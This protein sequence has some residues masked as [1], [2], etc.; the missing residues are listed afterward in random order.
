MFTTKIEGL[1]QCSNAKWGHLVREAKKEFGIWSLDTA[2][3]ELSE[4]MTAIILSMMVVN[5]QG[6]ES[7]LIDS[8]GV[9]PIAQ[10]VNI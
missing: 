5:R 6:K 7:I 10:R 1:R 3:Y 9:V 2:V 4:L 8:F